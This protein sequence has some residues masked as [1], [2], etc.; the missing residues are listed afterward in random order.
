[1]LHMKLYALYCLYSSLYIAPICMHQNKCNGATYK[2][3]HKTQSAFNIDKSIKVYLPGFG[4]ILNSVTSIRNV[5]ILDIRITMT[6][7]RGGICIW[8]FR[9]IVY[10]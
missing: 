10:F 4:N 1:M 6:H 8:M 5:F 3:N 2:I 7:H 9:I